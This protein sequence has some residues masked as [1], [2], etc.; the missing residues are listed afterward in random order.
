MPSV[1]QGFCTGGKVKGSG[2]NKHV[3][4]PNPLALL[5]KVP[6]GFSKPPLSVGVMSKMILSGCVGVIKYRCHAA[7]RR[8]GGPEMVEIE[9]ATKLP[10][11]YV[12]GA[13]SIAAHS[14]AADS[15][16]A[17]GQEY[18]PTAE[19]VDPADPVADQWIVRS[20]EQRRVPVVKRSR[21]LLDYCTGGHKGS[22]PV[23]RP[24]R[25]WPWTAPNHWENG[26]WPACASPRR[27]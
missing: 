27:G 7:D 1:A 16:A 6:P 23:A 9:F 11:D 15:N 5:P 4:W 10:G 8:T 14:D 3:G 22:R 21:G 12:I 19:D 18:E 2:L 17:L 24:N 25:G 20:A 26:C 13:G